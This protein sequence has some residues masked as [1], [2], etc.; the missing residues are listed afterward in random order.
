[1]L[2]R[3][4]SFCLSRRPLV[5][6]CFAAFLAIGFAAFTTLNIIG[7]TTTAVALDTTVANVV[8][9][10]FVSGAAG[11]SATFQNAAIEIVKQ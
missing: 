2:P 4:I 11:S 5:L 10:T 8:E 3:L 6:I 7:I 1:M 9:L